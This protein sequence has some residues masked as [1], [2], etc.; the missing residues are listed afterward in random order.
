[1]RIKE[2]GH[3]LKVW[4][5]YKDMR[6]HKQGEIDGILRDHGGVAYYGKWI[7]PKSDDLMAK[8]KAIEDSYAV[9]EEEENLFKETE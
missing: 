6:H 1:M 2:H 5:D 3:L 7:V 9:N 4:I 8:L